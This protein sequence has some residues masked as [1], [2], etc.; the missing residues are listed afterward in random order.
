M[1]KEN[2]RLQQQIAK[3]KDLVKTFP[4]VKEKQN[5]YSLESQLEVASELAKKFEKQNEELR[6]TVVLLRK[7]I[8]FLHNENGTLRKFLGG[9]DGGKR[10]LDSFPKAEEKVELVP[11]VFVSNLRK[12]K[13]KIAKAGEAKLQTIFSALSN[14]ANNRAQNIVAEFDKGVDIEVL[15]REIALKTT[16]ERKEKE[17]QMDRINRQIIRWISQIHYI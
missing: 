8:T 1:E 13:D 10:I 14:T 2:D 11:P 4:T 9:L 15:T 6:S 7:K 3:Y 5:S 12:P 17:K 16:Q